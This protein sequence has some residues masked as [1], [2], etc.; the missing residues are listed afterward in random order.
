[1]PKSIHWPKLEVINVISA[2]RRKLAEMNAGDFLIL[3]GW[4]FFS[5]INM[6]GIR[7]IEKSIT[8]AKCKA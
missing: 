2:L 3:K 4:G 5:L 1:M 6:E 7:V 8:Y